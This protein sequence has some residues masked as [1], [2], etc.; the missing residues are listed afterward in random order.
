MSSET[1]TKKRPKHLNV[2]LL[3]LQ[4]PFPGMVSIVHRITGAG[5]FIMLWF[6]IWLFDKS[7]SSQADFT[8]IVGWLRHPLV[9]L[10]GWVMV[11]AFIFHFCMGIRYLLLDMDIGVSLKWAR[12]SAFTVAVLSSIIS[13]VLLFFVIITLFPEV[14]AMLP[15]VERLAL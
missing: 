8:E 11:W 1:V 14:K 6:A 9:F 5:L 7:L 12:F 13:T 2:F 10:V 15:F 3:G 4:L